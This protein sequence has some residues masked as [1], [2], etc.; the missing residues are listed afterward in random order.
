MKHPA[1]GVGQADASSSLGHGSLDGGSP[2]VE[3]LPVS[4]GDDEDAGSTVRC[5]HV[6]RAEIDPLRIEPEAGKVSKDATEPAGSEPGYVLDDDPFGRELGGDPPELWPEPPR[7][8][9]AAAGACNTDGLARE[10]AAE[11]FDLF[12]APTLHLLNRSKE[13]DPR[14]SRAKHLAAERIVLGLPRDRAEPR[15]LEPQVEAPDRREE[16]PDLHFAAFR[17]AASASIRALRAAIRTAR[18]S[19]RASA[20]AASASRTRLAGRT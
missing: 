13:L 17:A 5:A 9:C 12:R 19:L 14:P 10:A 18:A 2:S 11:Y 1:F 6:G 15:T 7:V 3:S 4:M 20:F 8:I 16:R